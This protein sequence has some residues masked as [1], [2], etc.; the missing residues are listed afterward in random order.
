[1]HESCKQHHIRIV[2]PYLEKRTLRCR[3]SNSLV[4]MQ[5]LNSPWEP[6]RRLFQTMPSER[7][8]DGTFSGIFSST[9]LLPVYGSKYSI[10]KLSFETQS[11][12]TMIFFFLFFFFHIF[13]TIWFL[14][15]VTPHDGNPFHQNAHRALNFQVFPFKFCMHNDK[16]LL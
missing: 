6:V 11:S 8:N 16:S 14:F 12:S 1:M 2:I 13:F 10:F 4:M 7:N 3:Y 15:K 5:A 9:F